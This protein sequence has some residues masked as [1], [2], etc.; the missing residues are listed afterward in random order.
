[1][2][3]LKPCP[4]CGNNALLVENKKHKA[5]PYHVRCKSIKCGN[6]TARWNTEDGAIAAWNRRVDKDGEA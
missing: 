6:K 3:E 4:F 1:M 5:F 2:M